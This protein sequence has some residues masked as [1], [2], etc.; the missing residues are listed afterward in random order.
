MSGS[1]GGPSIWFPA[2]EQPF[3]VHNYRFAVIGVKVIYLLELSER[4]DNHVRR[5]KRDSWI[6][7]QPNRGCNGVLSFFNWADWQCAHFTVDPRG[8]VPHRP[9]G[10]PALTVVARLLRCLKGLWQNLT[11]AV[12][13]QKVG[14]L[15][16]DGAFPGTDR[17]RRAP[18]A[19][20][21]F[22]T[23]PQRLTRI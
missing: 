18:K 22:G 11:C 1:V 12:N 20:R 5:W 15:R 9:A 14:R 17:A 13:G 8:A 7:C 4:L 10:R 23:G 21:G 6:G 19:R 2:L 16:M 3:N